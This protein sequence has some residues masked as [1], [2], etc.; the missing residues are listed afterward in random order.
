LPEIISKAAN[1]A[2]AKA[3]QA[4]SEQ[5]DQVL[6]AVEDENAALRKENR[7]LKDFIKNNL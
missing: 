5:Y 6:K 2:A 1:D 4:V 7:A 3:V